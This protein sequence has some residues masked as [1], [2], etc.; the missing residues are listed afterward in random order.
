MV[1]TWANDI[2]FV[3]GFEYSPPQ[4]LTFLTSFPSDLHEY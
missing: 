3:N 4:G 1:F 2:Q